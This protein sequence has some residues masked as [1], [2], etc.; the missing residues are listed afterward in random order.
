MRR[1]TLVAILAG[2]AAMGA[3]A[4]AYA[5]VGAAPQPHD[6]WRAW[7]WTPALLVALAAWLYARGARALWARAGHG[8]GV[9]PWRTRCYAAGLVA[10]ALALASPIDAAA[11]SLF[12]VHMVQHLL[13]VV[14]AAPLVVLGEPALVTLWALPRDARIVLAR[15]WRGLRALA[16]VARQPLVAW[17]LHVATLW[18]WH[19]RGPYE[20]AVRHPLVHVVEHAS[21][22]ATALLFWH[23][24]AGRRA[25]RHLGPGIAALYL[26]A[27]ALQSTAL[28]ALLTV[29]TRPWYGVHLATTG[30]WGLTPL[31]DQQLAG[32]IMWIPAGLAYTVAFL[33]S[34]AT[35]LRAD[36]APRLQT[37]LRIS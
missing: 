13:L 31:E 30:P 20:T 10:I 37:K 21:F 34:L 16:H 32:L 14:V 35:A 15:R 1:T 7:S 5:H 27:A 11:E 8:R 24:L 25:R 6:L 2:A 18:A 33:A 17:T 9:A 12:A 23:V 36:A 19:A 4:A 26:F 3:P 29:A 28:G 22:F